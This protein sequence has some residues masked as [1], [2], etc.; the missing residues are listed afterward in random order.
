[1]EDY[2]IIPA[3][4]EEQNVPNVVRGALKYSSHVIVVDDGSSDKTSENARLA[5]AI[6]LQH[7]INL[8]KGNALKTGSDFAVRHGAERIVFIDADMQH[9]PDDIPKALKMLEEYEIILGYREYDKNMPFI[10]RLGNFGIQM[11]FRIL[12]GINLKDTQSGFKAFNTRIYDNIRWL[13]SGYS[14][15]SEI[16]ARVARNRIKYKQFRIKTRYHDNYKGTTVFDGFKIAKDMLWFRI[17]K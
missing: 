10:Y 7:P 9:D 4:N 12:Y 13:S 14:V 15:E 11:I 16:A 17:I 1:M 2:I 5:G 6:V 8:G 3:Y